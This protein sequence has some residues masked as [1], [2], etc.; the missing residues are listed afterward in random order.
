MTAKLWRNW[1][2]SRRDGP[3]WEENPEFGW[4][5]YGHRKAGEPFKGKDRYSSKREAEDAA[6]RALLTPGEDG[7]E[8]VCH[9]LGAFQEGDHP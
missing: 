6:K 3:V 1:W 4:V 8:S 2:S 7:P 9:Y 5:N